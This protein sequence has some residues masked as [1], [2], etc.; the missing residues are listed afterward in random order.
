MAYLYFIKVRIMMSLAYRFE[1][2][3]SVIIQFV[4]L[5]VNAFFWRA[6][7][8][9][10]ET[11]Q[12]TDLNQMLIY[13]VMSVLLGCFFC[14][15]VENKL[16]SKIRDG[17]VAS[18]YVKPISLFGM[19][20]AEDI[21]EI[22][23]NITQRVIPLL[24]FSCIFIAPPI[25]ASG[26]HFVLFL[27]SACASFFILWFVAALFGLLNFW[28]ID[29]GPIGGAKD[30][31]IGFLSGSVIPIWFF[32][33]TI[34]NILAYTPFI[35]MYQTPIGIYIGRTGLNEAVQA[36]AVQIIWVL[37]FYGIFSFTK[38]RAVKNIMVQGG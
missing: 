27:L 24:V 36:I 29:I 7:Y 18:D 23:V 17:S 35:Y 32:P 28:L 30:I 1:A 4:I 8:A 38:S 19:F 34:R 26:L 10:Y 13:S 37:V 12:D 14:K 22:V 20:F 2:F 6:V 25:P 21:G 5:S 11:V 9:N 3:S 33:E 15:T 31:I 16:R